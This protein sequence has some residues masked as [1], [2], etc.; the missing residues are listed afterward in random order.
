MKPKSDT[1]KR[2]AARVAALLDKPI[3]VLTGEVTTKREWI[4]RLV[5]HGRVLRHMNVP[6]YTYS[7]TR[8]NRMSDAEQRIY[9]QKLNERKHIFAA[10]APDS[11][12]YQELTKT[13]AAYFVEIGGRSE[14]AE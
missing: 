4:A 6:K 3:R 11:N 14:I 10:C 2:D 8:F 1:T 7:R 5:A 12:S 13:E 9:M